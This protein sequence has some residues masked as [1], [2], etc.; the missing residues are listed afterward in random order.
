MITV[1]GS[2]V[3]GS[4]I[5]LSLARRGLDVRLLYRAAEEGA[6]FTNQKWHH[7]GMLYPSERVLKEAWAAYQGA[8]PLILEHIF[9]AH[10]PARFLALRRDTFDQRRKWFDDWG[11][12]DV[13][14]DWQ[15]LDPSDLVPFPGIVGG[16][17][18]PDRAI[19]FP[20]L[21]RHLR[22]EAAS[23]GADVVEA[24][25][26]ELLFERRFRRVHGVRCRAN[27]IESELD[28]DHV[29]VSA[30]A[31]S[32]ALAERVPDIR[33]PKIARKKCVVLSYPTELVS[34]ITVC[35][36]VQKRDGSRAD[37][38]LVPCH[39]QTLAAGVD[40]EPVTEIDDAR[41]TSDEVDRLTAEL[42]QWCPAVERHEPTP[43]ICVK[44]ERDTGKGHPDVLPKAYGQRTHGIDGVTVAFPGKASFMFELARTVAATLSAST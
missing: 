16:F 18:G 20:A 11:L 36:D 40:W 43:H 41:A 28:S 21:I 24:N 15:V 23:R 4:A 31:W 30:G 13:G 19:D 37:T 7:S 1:V 35:L 33:L 39:G 6:S 17:R 10:E 42:A 22:S 2:G 5:A 27:G 12:R 34:G 29:V 25:V 32:V 26:V 8:D 9:R 44:T 38:I 14:L 3:A